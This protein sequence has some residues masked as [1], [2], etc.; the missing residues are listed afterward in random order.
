MIADHRHQRAAGVDPLGVME[1]TVPVVALSS[2]IHEVASHNVK[3]RIGPRA[4]SGVN[5]RAPPIKAILRVAH[6]D[7][8]KGLRARRGSG[9]LSRFRPTGFA[10]VADGVNIGRSRRQ[11]AQHDRVPVNHRIVQQSRRFG[12]GGRG[13]RARRLSWIE[14]IVFGL[15][16][17]LGVTMSDPGAGAPL[18]RLGSARILTPSQH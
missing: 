17:I 7:E 9:E 5:E 12:P 3:A 18:D 14:A 1:K 13:S 15:F 6:V 4:K 11:P 10:A 16:L 8:R 2:S